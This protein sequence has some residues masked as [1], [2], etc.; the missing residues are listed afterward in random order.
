M[1]EAQD[2]Y[3]ETFRRL[4]WQ[5]THDTEKGRKILE[6]KA[7]VLGLDSDVCLKSV[8]ELLSK[9][10]QYR[11]FLEVIY[12]GTDELAESEETELRE[13][14]ADAGLSAEDAAELRVSFLKSRQAEHP[15]PATT[16]AGD[17]NASDPRGDGRRSKKAHNRKKARSQPEEDYTEGLADLLIPLPGT[18]LAMCFTAE[19]RADPF[20]HLYFR[21]AVAARTEF[22]GAL[23]QRFH[24]STTLA[25]FDYD[26]LQALALAS[27]GKFAEAVRAAMRIFL[28]VKGPSREDILS[29]F[30][31][32]LL[33][34]LADAAQTGMATAQD[35]V[36]LD[37]AQRAFARGSSS[38]IAIG[39]LGFMLTVGALNGI[40]KA[41]GKVSAM[42]ASNSLKARLNGDLLRTFEQSMEVF[43]TF[44]NE[45]FVKLYEMIAI[46]WGQSTG[47]RSCGEINEDIVQARDLLRDSESAKGDPRRYTSYLLQALAL[48]PCCSEAYLALTDSLLRN[49]DAQVVV[50]EAALAREGDP[51]WR[52]EFGSRLALLKV[53]RPGGA[54]D[55]EV[56]FLESLGKGVDIPANMVSEATQKDVAEAKSSCG[57]E[58][59]ASSS[60]L[61]I[62]VNPDS[63]WVLSRAGV[64]VSGLSGSGRRVTLAS[65]YRDLDRVSFGTDL[66]SYLTLTIKDVD[67]PIRV[68][69]DEVS[70]RVFDY[71][72]DLF[73]TWKTLTRL[74]GTESL[75]AVAGGSL[76]RLELYVGRVLKSRALSTIKI[77]WTSPKDYYLNELGRAWGSGRPDDTVVETLQE[78][79]SRFGLAGGQLAEAEAMVVRDRY[80]LHIESRCG[81]PLSEVLAFIEQARADFGLP[82]GD[83]KAVEGDVLGR[84]YAREYEQQL[85]QV[86]SLGLGEQE[87]AQRLQELHRRF[88]ASEA[89]VIELERERFGRAITVD[90][91]R[92]STAELAAELRKEYGD[93]G[94]GLVGPEELAQVTGAQGRF[95]L[96][97]DRGEGPDY[98]LFAI[99]NPEK[100]APEV[101][102]TTDMIRFGT[103]GAD[104]SVAF[105][106]IDNIAI[107]RDGFIVDTDSEHIEIPLAN[108]PKEPLVAM[109]RRLIFGFE[110]GLDPERRA[111]LQR[112]LAGMKNRLGGGNDKRYSVAGAI[113]M[114]HLERF[115][116]AYGQTSRRLHPEQVVGLFQDTSS[117][118]GT[119]GV[120]VTRDGL[121]VIMGGIK[122]YLLFEN[123]SGE[124][125]VRGE[126]DRAGIICR[127]S[128][129][130]YQFW[131][132]NPQW[133]G[134]MADLVI[135]MYRLRNGGSTREGRTET[136]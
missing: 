63:T 47:L 42:V 92:Y 101:I 52:T 27:L 107:S 77:E 78:I 97:E 37:R 45:G 126:R 104:S 12:Q 38:T 79:K 31:W 74:P 134:A 7:K 113:S 117:R 25:W 118:D 5:N 100:D 87:L 136:R 21:A 68:P 57:P 76:E 112:T 67:Y 6:Q 70:P 56:S 55:D 1:S 8:A 124:P 95:A 14:G 43:E 35:L 94:V 96:S 90:D 51:E 122:G 99:G 102:V 106:E 93:L 130:E 98:M 119:Q 133:G 111:V 129:K 26:N 120:M 17:Q 4:Y 86:S 72:H 116:R 20:Y 105:D 123:L 91:T 131:F 15:L 32:P 81:R 53:T 36:E 46:A 135:Q 128:T 80:R 103:D 109:L 110:R 127:T 125:E 10:A 58:A 30:D 82:S 34:D 16:P 59:A 83:S 39:S 73:E 48:N 75:Q 88:G 108:V 69:T 66:N 19:R 85:V 121:R 71:I 13:F 28:G 11:D 3:L 9:Y 33:G 64:Y 60:I 89:G 41:V 115:I 114:P 44:C 132:P 61:A 54:P 49:P 22:L 24:S 84:Y 40:G 23:A 18:D 65:S 29:T 2:K 50:L 62:W